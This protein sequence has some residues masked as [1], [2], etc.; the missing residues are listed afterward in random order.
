MAHWTQYRQITHRLTAPDEI[1]I[2]AE[3]QTQAEHRVLQDWCQWIVDEVRHAS[4]SM[5]RAMRHGAWT[6]PRVGFENPEATIDIRPAR[7]ARYIPSKWILELDK[8]AVLDRLI[9][10]VYDDPLAFIRELVQNALDAMRCRMYADLMAEGIDPPEYPTQVDEPRRRRYPLELRIEHRDVVNDLSG[11]QQRQQVLVVEDCGIGMDKDVIER[12]F[13]QIGRSYYTTEEFRRAFRFVPTSRF[14]VGFLSVFAVSDYVA[15]ETY[16]PE[17]S[18]APL[19]LVL[20]GPRN[21][22]LTEKGSRRGPG[23]KI[24]VALREPLDPGQLTTAVTRWCLRVEFPIVVH[25]LD[26]VTTVRA[27]TPTDFIYEMRDIPEK[28]SR[29]LVR[30]AARCAEV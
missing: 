10:D 28:H 4:I 22:L 7:E 23:T 12:F 13:L 27:E 16:M 15:V 19:R 20:T 1:A 5:A 9:H 14:G 2:T 11:E 25:D 8:E 29:F 30:I 17:R 6:P 26:R 18:P 21:Y 24:E 3:C